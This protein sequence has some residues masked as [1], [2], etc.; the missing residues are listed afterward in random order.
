MTYDNTDS[1]SDGVIDAPVDND[2]VSTGEENGRLQVPEFGTVQEAHNALSNDGGIIELTESVSETGI[3]I[4]KPIKLVGLG[5]GD[6]EIDGDIKNIDVSGGDGIHIKTDGVTI[7]DLRIEGDSASGFGIKQGISTGTKE[8][9]E[10]L[11]TTIE[12]VLIN[13]LGGTGYLIQGRSQQNSY[14]LVVRDCDVGFHVDLQNTDDYLSASSSTLLAL[15]GNS[16]DGFKLNAAGT[17]GMGGN[18]FS[19]FVSEGNGGWGLNLVGGPGA[20]RNR[21]Q[22]Y[23][24][25]NNNSGAVYADEGYPLV[26]DFKSV[27]DG[28]V[29]F[30]GLYAEQLFTDKKRIWGTKIFQQQNSG[31]IHEYEENIGFSDLKGPRFGPANN[32]Q[33]R[34]NDSNDQLEIR[35]GGT[36]VLKLNESVDVIFDEWARQF[37]KGFGTSNIQDLS[38]ISGEFD[39]AIARDDGTNFNQSGEYGWWDNSNNVW[40]AF[41]DPTVTA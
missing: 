31:N 9:R 20:Q 34:W 6:P 10:T 26:L 21:F 4:T 30:N 8:E 33:V 27:S 35:V 40:R 1:N 3:E 12:N 2:S 37:S 28:T 24:T 23:G 25:E 18:V 29:N 5:D 38:N 16:S 14:N 41:S 7:R 15:G 19:G 36:S 17:E 39:G 11:N 13:G 22:G 32:A